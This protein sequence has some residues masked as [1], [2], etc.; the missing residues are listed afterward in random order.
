MHD[1]TGLTFIEI[2]YLPIDEYLLF[3]KDAFIFLLNQT[4]DGR[5]YLEKCWIM[6]Q[7]KPDRAALREKFGKRGG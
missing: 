4:E 2:Q 1:H 6:Q 3:R 5:E 7:T